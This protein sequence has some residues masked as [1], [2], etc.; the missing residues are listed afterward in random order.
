MRF[1]DDGGHLVFRID[2]FDARTV[3][4]TCVSRRDGSRCVFEIDLTLV[5]PILLDDVAQ[6]DITVRLSAQESA[7]EAARERRAARAA[8]AAERRAAKAPR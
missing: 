8:R 3:R 1:F 5:P 4:Q 7:V 2:N 6:V